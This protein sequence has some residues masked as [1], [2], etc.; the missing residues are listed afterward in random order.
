MA[1]GVVH[2][3]EV[4]EIEEED[5]HLLPSAGERML[6]PIVEQGSVGEAGQRV[7]QCAVVER[8]LEGATLMQRRAKVTHDA[9]ETPDDEQEEQYAAP[10]DGRD[11]D[12]PAGGTLKDEH[13]RRHE[14]CRRQ[15]RQAPAREARLPDLDRLRHATHGRVQRRGAPQDRGHQPPGF[16]DVPGLV[17]SLEDHDR[18]REVGHEQGQQR[19]HEQVERRDTTTRDQEDA[20][21]DAQQEDVKCG[22]GQR[23]RDL[24]DRGERVGDQR[25][26]EEG[27]ADQRDADG[28]DER[29]DDPSPVPARD[30]P[31]D[32]VQD[33]ERDEGQATEVEGVR[34]RW[35]RLLAELRQDDPR[36]IAGG[37]QGEADREDDPRPHLRR[38]VAQDAHQ[39]HERGQHAGKLVDDFLRLRG[40]AGP[41]VRREVH[42]TCQQVGDGQPVVAVQHLG[43]E[44]REHGHLRFAAESPGCV[45]GS[46]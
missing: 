40:Q 3:L 17:R 24:G 10:G 45:H 7:V 21:E 13:R 38:S 37:T 27:P 26:H 2:R 5:G 29:V 44:A 23:G 28:D 41:E 18:V 42:R 6:E 1:E 25:L 9:A 11:V 22:I 35:E 33:R 14:R 16:D 19:E 32:E 30:P 4:V 20:H 12:R 8:G 31:A 36:P 43:P 15:E 39:D 34:D 46:G